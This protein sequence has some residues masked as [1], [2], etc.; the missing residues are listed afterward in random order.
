MTVL[1]TKL[2]KIYEK[3]VL[4]C[5]CHALLLNIII[6]LLSRRSIGETF[7]YI[8]GSPVVFLCNLGIIM[9]TFVPCFIV[10]RKAFCQ[11][12]ITLLW[13]VGAIANFCLQ[14][15]RTMPFSIMDI[16]CVKYAVAVAAKYYTVIEMILM[17]LIAGAVVFGLIWAFIKA[18]RQPKK[19]IPYVKNLVI[20]GM[21]VI[22]VVFSTTLGVRTDILAT[23]YGNIT[24]AYL[25]YGFPYCFCMGIIESGINRPE[26]YSEEAVLALLEEKENLSPDK[27]PN[28]IF[29]Q[30]ES[31]YDPA[32]IPGL[33]CSEDP[34]DFWHSLEDNYTGGVFRVP[35]VG[36]GTAN[37]EFETISG[38]NIDFFG[39]GE[40][41]YRTVLLDEYCGSMAWDL[42][43]YG[44]TTVAMH[45]ND[46]TFYWRDRAFDKLGFDYF[47]SIEYMDDLSYTES[48]W[49]LDSVLTPEI[50]KCLDASDDQ[51]YIYCI[52]VQ[53]HGSYPAEAFEPTYDIG[54]S[55]DFSEEE[56][57]Q[58]LYYVDQMAQMDD[59]IEELVHALEERDEE[60]VLIMYGDHLPALPF[61]DGLAESDALYETRYVLWSNCGIEGDGRTLEAYLAPAYITE[62]LGIEGGVLNRYQHENA[63]R[64]G[65]LPGLEMLQYD[66][67]YG[68][69]FAYGGAFPYPEHE[70]VMGVTEIN[71]TNYAMLNDGFTVFGTGFTE[72]S[73]I[74]INGKLCETRFINS[75]ALI[76]DKVPAAGDVVC[77]AQAGEDSV[78]LSESQR[79]VMPRSMRYAE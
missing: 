63:G 20:V 57:Y 10:R 15:V 38:M 45:N 13:L 46:G 12:L 1:K 51:D 43:Q 21:I 4:F 42:K 47:Q 50:I 7:M 55:G 77:V 56:Y 73:H 61:A 72:F 40:Y 11:L 29:L 65:F 9:V 18:P 31:F 28:I 52:S 54:I 53:G 48:G 17:V 76:T 6:E 49:A 25:D 64:E 30:L 19:S 59:F 16:F 41:P 33:A 8:I 60:T 35:V 68:D 79:I 62:L 75:G 66:M 78:V 2:I 23:D 27:T 32:L 69:K 67:L 14:S 39:P 22:C 36:A 5:L 26:D 58:Y 44:Y 70:A 34:L 3:P 74:S 24:E 37:T 71:F